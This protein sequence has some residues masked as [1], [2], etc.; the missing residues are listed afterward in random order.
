MHPFSKLKA[1]V[2]LITIIADEEGYG[3]IF[4]VRLLAGLHF[5]VVWNFPVWLDALRLECFHVWSGFNK[6]ESYSYVLLTK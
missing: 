4:F 3:G 6:F 5:L 1:Q 2:D